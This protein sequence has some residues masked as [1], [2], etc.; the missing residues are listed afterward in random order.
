MI[1]YQ[2]T[3][4]DGTHVGFCDTKEEALELRSKTQWRFISR[5][6]NVYEICTSKVNKTLYSRKKIC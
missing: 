3:M 5:Y 2:V 4:N 6:C 1:R